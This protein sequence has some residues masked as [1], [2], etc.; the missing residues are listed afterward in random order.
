MIDMN[1]NFFK[2]IYN[3]DVIYHY[4]KSSTAVDYILYN[5]EL[6]FSKRQK[7]LDPLES[8]IPNRSTFYKTGGLNDNKINSEHYNQSDDLVNYISELEQNFYQIC[9]CKNTMGSDFASKNYLTQFHG[10]EE[11]FGFTKPRMWERYA[12]NYEGICLA[13]SRKRLL[14]RNK[15]KFKFID[16]NIEYLSYIDLNCKKIDDISGNHLVK[17]GL[18]KYK[19][20]LK[21]AAEMAFFCKHSDYSGEDEFRIGVYYDSEKCGAEKIRGEFQ[22]FES[23]MLD[24]QDCLEAIFISSF[25][26]ERQKQTLLKYADKFKIPIIEMVWKHNSFNAIDYRDSE[27]LFKSLKL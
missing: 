27:N 6:R 9:F 20:E 8:I 15:D 14:K 1:I 5:E 11:L 13:F 26:N 19:E 22:F 23:M 3:E 10:N 21:T 17:V 7:S 12:D 4:T 24:I 2:G 25:N 18:D 16:K